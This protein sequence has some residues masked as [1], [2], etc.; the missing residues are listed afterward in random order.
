[1]QINLLRLNTPNSVGVTFTE[2]AIREALK[3]LPP[4]VLLEKY[5]SEEE[6][7]KN[8]SDVDISKVVGR[9]VNM[10]IANSTLIGDVEYFNVPANT[11]T[12][13]ISQGYRHGIK[14]FGYVEAEKIASGIT[15]QSAMC[16]KLDEVPYIDL[17]ALI[18]FLGTQ[19]N[20]V[21]YIPLMRGDMIFLVSK[22]NLDKLDGPAKKLLQLTHY[23][24][25][26]FKV[27]C[28]R[29][30]FVKCRLPY[31]DLKQKL[32]FNGFGWSACDNLF[33]DVPTP[34]G[35]LARLRREQ[36]DIESKYT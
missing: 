17:N 27:E 1:M 26:I 25:F 34:G 36:A 15:I 6:F 23:A 2:D 32:Y 24:D 9:V 7:N 33:L 3:E 10:R 18:D 30:T 31:E 35:V 11:P 8:G 22:E 13:D 14:C 28:N 12:E 29:L 21:T 16:V 5:N 20:N 4:T 19:M